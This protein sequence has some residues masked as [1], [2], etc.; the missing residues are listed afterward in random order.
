MD[1]YLHEKK[2]PSKTHRD[3]LS[4]KQPNFVLSTLRKIQIRLTVKKYSSFMMP[5][6]VN[7]GVMGGIFKSLLFQFSVFLPR[8]VFPCKPATAFLTDLDLPSAKKVVR[9]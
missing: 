3:R 1:V 2:L 7:V 6:L 9:W 5:Q 8:M 4:I